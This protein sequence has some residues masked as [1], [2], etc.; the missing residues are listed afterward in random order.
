LRICARLIPPGLEVTAFRQKGFLQKHQPQTI[1]IA[2]PETRQP[3]MP[4]TR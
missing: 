4:Y 1:V 3:V 2:L